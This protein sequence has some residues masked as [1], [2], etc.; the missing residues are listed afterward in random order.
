MAVEAGNDIAM[1]CHQVET[2][3]QA[4]SQLKEIPNQRIDDSLRRI[5]RMKK[6]IINP[7]K[8]TQELWEQINADIMQLR[9]D[10]L[11]RERALEEPDDSGQSHSPVEDY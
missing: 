10:V 7:F 6:R 3:P 5:E 8:F 9:I 2:A 4:L 11:G 1:I